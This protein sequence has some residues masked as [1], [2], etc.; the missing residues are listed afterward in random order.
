MFI[1]LGAADRAGDRTG[2]PGSLRRVLE[3]EHRRRCRSHGER[4]VRFGVVEGKRD[5]SLRRG[6]HQYA[7]GSRRGAGSLL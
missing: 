5:E 2:L 4:R 1:L 3:G 6:R 7:E